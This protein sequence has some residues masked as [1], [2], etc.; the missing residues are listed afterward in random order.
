MSKAGRTSRVGKQLAFFA[1]YV[2]INFR[3][4]LEYRG[5]F[6]SRI[7]SMLVNDCMWLWY[8]AIYFTRFPVVQ[9]WQRD[10]VMALWAFVGVF[11]GLQATIAGGA[12][13][14]AASIRQG[15]M[16]FYLALPKNVLLH[17]LVSKMDITAIGDIAFGLA[18]YAVFCQVSLGGLCLLLIASV[19]AAMLFTGF[20]VIMASLTFFIGNSEGLAS[21]AWN[22]FIHFSTYPSGIFRGFTKMLLFTLLPAGFINAVPVRVIRNFDPH[23]FALLLAAGIGFFALGWVVFFAGLRRYESGNLMT[24][25]M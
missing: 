24:I 16:D 25:R 22:A 3:T 12:T 9:G 23:Y 14:L 17:A 15:N 10:D 18:V 2:G 13:G 4:A 6:W 1:S 21:Q 8:W 19:A 5:S 7:F 11:F 20:Q